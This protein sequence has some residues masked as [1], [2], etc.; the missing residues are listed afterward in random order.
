MIR[1]FNFFQASSQ[2]FCGDSTKYNKVPDRECRFPCSGNR[3]ENCGGI[4]RMS[5][6]NTGIFILFKKKRTQP[7][8][9]SDK[10]VVY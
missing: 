6:Y 3:D 7:E 9:Q 8:A 5:V 10:C 1:N 2:C 4:W